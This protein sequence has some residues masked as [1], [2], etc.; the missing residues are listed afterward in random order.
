MG[1]FRVRGHFVLITLE[2]NSYNVKLNTVNVLTAVKF[3]ALNIITLVDVPIAFS[4]F[5]A[6]NVNKNL[7]SFW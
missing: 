1:M 4:L 6:K 3:T 5:K 7:H 2:I